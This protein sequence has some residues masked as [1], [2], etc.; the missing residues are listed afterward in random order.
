MPGEDLRAR[1]AWYPVLREDPQKW[2]RKCRDF[3]I[4]GDVQRV[5]QWARGAKNR[6]VNRGSELDK[7][8]DSLKDE[9]VEELRRRAEGVAS[10]EEIEG[11]KT[12]EWA[13]VLGALLAPDLKMAQVRRILGS[14]MRIETGVQREGP[15]SFKRAEAEYLRVYL[16]YAAGRKEEARPLLSVLEP[17]IRKVREGE[18]GWNDF[19]TLARFVRAVVAYH[20]F[21]GGGE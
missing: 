20:K 15:E 16:A 19:R 18:E 13:Y 3:L 6:K 11:E 12:V 8:L 7:E 4:E 1:A 14:I 2:N 9:L 5:L 21:F 10:L 17:L